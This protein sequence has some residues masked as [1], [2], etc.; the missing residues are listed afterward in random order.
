MSDTTELETLQPDQVFDGGDLDCGSGLILLI[1]EQMLKVPEGGLLEMRSREPTVAD[2]LPPWCRMAGHDYLGKV[3]TAHFV[4]YFMRRGAGAKEDRQALEA[5]KTRAKSYEWR[6]RTRSTGH[7]KSTVY[8]RNFSFEVG[9]PASFEEKDQHPS[10]VEY[11]L[12]ALAASLATG[13]A[14]EAARAGLQVDDI[15]I[16]V[17]GKLDNVLVLLGLE[18]GNPAFSGIEL[19]CFASTLDDEEQVRAAWK[20]A[21]QRSPIV[22]TL[23]KAVDLNLKLAIV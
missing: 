21:V 7:L 4:R 20:Q 1:R 9:Q 15:E 12:G 22:A 8:C 11:L 3:E 10:A 19:K 13:F 5:D 14:T 2:D 23:Q 18:E 17:K 6:L 16:T